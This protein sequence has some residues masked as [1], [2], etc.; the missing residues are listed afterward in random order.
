MANVGGKQWVNIPN[1]WILWILE[2]LETPGKMCGNSTLLNGDTQGF[3]VLEPWG[4]LRIPDGKLRGSKQ[5]SFGEANG[6][7]NRILSQMRQMY[8]LFTYMKG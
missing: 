4:T 2:M 8:G 3:R 1:Q 7:R 6:T 5:G